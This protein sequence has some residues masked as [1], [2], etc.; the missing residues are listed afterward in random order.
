MVP[1]WPRAERTRGALRGTEVVW[2][3]DA[4]EAFF[5]QVQGSGRVRLR[6]GTI[7]R[8]GYADTNGH[9]Y[10][11]IGRVLIDRGELTLEQA[12]MQGITAWARANPSASPNC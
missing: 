6:D 7:V 11:S 8:V 2:V 5:L 12:S 9:P 10:R 1:Y 3:D 4:V